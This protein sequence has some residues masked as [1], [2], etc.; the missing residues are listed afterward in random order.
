MRLWVDWILKLSIPIRLKNDKSFENILLEKWKIL[1]EKLSKKNHQKIESFSDDFVVI[2]WE[3]KEFNE[4]LLSSW[5][6][7]RIIENKNNLLN[8]SE[9]NS[10][11][12]NY[13]Q[14]LLKQ[15]LYDVSLPIL[16]KYSDLIW[17]AF[18]K[19]IIKE[20]KSKRGSCSHHQRIVLNLKLIHLPLKYLEYVIIHEACH[21]KEKNHSYKFWALVEKYYPDY[22]GTRK[23]L[24]NFRI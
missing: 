12:H 4:F 1:I 11:W 14:N 16:Q 2:F 23:E 13:L 3:K 18:Q 6:W 24:R 15:K 9:L 5:T 10:E 8:D 19:L 21:L 22:K 17:I 7:F 20:L